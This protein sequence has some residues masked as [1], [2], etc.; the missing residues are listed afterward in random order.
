MRTVATMR[1]RTLYPAE[2]P[3]SSVFELTPFVFRWPPPDIPNENDGD[4][5]GN[6]REDTDLAAG[7]FRVGMWFTSA[8]ARIS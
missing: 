3:S 7:G 6:Q 8:H 5:D 2:C 4:Q 1:E